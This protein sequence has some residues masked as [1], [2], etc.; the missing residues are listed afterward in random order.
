MTSDK[1]NVAVTQNGSTVS[2]LAINKKNLLIAFSESGGAV[3]L[4]H[5]NFGPNRPT[6]TT[7]Y[8]ENITATKE[9]LFITTMQ[10][11]D[12]ECE[13]GSSEVYMREGEQ[14]I[15]FTMTLRR[16]KER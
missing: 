13:V 12:M 8:P 6:N 3:Q 5:R 11:E 7:I 9:N 4:F 10:F 1:Y 15:K 14:R 2:D 16:G